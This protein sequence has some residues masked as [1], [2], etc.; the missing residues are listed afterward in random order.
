MVYLIQSGKYLKI[1]Y[2]ENLMSR[3]KAYDTHNPDYQLLGVIDGDKTVEKEIHNKFSY[4]RVKG[5]WFQ[6]SK[7][8]RRE[9]RGEVEESKCKSKTKGL[10]KHELVSFIEDKVDIDNL[11]HLDMT[12][13]NADGHT[14]KYSLSR[15]SD[16]LKFTHT[17]IDTQN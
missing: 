10:Q 1:G 13:I 4:L 12:I 16:S 2:A 6:D 5:E 17:F 9:F 3:L 7:E 15:E 14:Y 11:L 8:I